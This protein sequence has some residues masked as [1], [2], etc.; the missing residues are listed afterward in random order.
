M[1]FVSRPIKRSIQRRA[2]ILAGRSMK[3]QC[4]TRCDEPDRGLGDCGYRIGLAIVCLSG[5]DQGM[6]SATKERS[7]QL[8]QYNK[9]LKTWLKDNAHCRAC[10]VLADY[11]G[12]A[13]H[14]IKLAREC[15]HMRGRNGDLLLDERW[16]LPVCV[17]C[18]RWITDHGK[19]AREL[20]LSADVDYRNQ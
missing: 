19:Q 4:Q 10:E 1:R 15:H 16:W 11:S 20:G 12:H 13:I 5:S 6:K 2:L 9:R 18:H 17:S 8:R 3:F 14:V 7:K